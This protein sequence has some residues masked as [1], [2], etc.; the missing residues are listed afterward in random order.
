M[1]NHNRNCIA[2]AI[3]AVNAS[4]AYENPDAFASGLLRPKFK[5]EKVVKDTIAIFEK[6]PLSDTPDD[7]GELPEAVAVIVLDY[8]GVRPSRLVKEKL[9]PQRENAVYY[10]NFIRRI[11]G[12][13]RKRFTGR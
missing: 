4:P 12:L 2:G 9:A 3:V 7:T 13:Y 11:C 5:M 1:D 6:I 10:N 8:D